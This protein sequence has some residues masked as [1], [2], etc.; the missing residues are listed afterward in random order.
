MVTARF[1]FWQALAGFAVSALALIAGTGIYASAIGAVASLL[2]SA[3]YFVVR[4]RPFFAQF[5]ERP[6]HGEVSWAR[7]IW[8]FQ[9]RI[10]VS[11][12][13]GYFIFDI[14]NPIAF[15]FCG[16]VAAGRLGMSLQMIRMIFNV[17][18]T[19][20]YTK[21][22]RFGIL[23]AA[24]SWTELDILW[25]RSTVQSFVFCLLG[26]TSFLGHVS[27]AG[28]YFPKILVR[29]A[30]FAVNAWLAGAMLRPGVDH[31]D[32]HGTAGAQARAVYVALRAQCG[33]KRGVH[34]P[35][36]PALGHHGRGHGLCA[37]HLGRLCARL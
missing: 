11:W 18:M 12:M 23:V 20:I 14:I 2:L 28:H 7:E 10:A 31:R 21:S 33:F 29:L 32:G 37:G 8:P 15:Y 4:W 26:M 25:R 13:S 6:R 22:P 34:P 19:W 5:L 17:A 36:R 27:L 9:W 30:P 24:R 1:G 3:G 16:P 35:A